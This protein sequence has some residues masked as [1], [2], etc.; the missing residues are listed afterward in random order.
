MKLK[1]ILVKNVTMLKNKQVK[2]DSISYEADGIINTKPEEN[3]YFKNPHINEM[4]KS[5]RIGAESKSSYDEAKFARFLKK[6]GHEV[7]LPQKRGLRNN[8]CQ[9][10]LPEYQNYVLA[11][12]RAQG[13]LVTNDDN[14][15]SDN[16]NSK[17]LKI[18]DESQKYQNSPFY[19]SAKNLLLLGSR[20]LN[21]EINNV[22]N[23][24]SMLKHYK[25]QDT[26]TSESEQTRKLSIQDRK[27]SARKSKLDTDVKEYASII[28]SYEKIN[29]TS[30][31]R[32][33]I[34][35]YRLKAGNLKFPCLPSNFFEKPEWS[36]KMPHTR[37]I[38]NINPS[39][40]GNPGNIIDKF[41]II[42]NDTKTLGKMHNIRHNLGKNPLAE[43]KSKRNCYKCDREDDFFLQKIYKQSEPTI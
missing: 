23:F 21:S 3:V 16:E 41:D 43:I 12:E 30:R 7:H 6:P 18:D 25:R 8:S 32:S 26:E 29:N 5:S 40:L 1:C 35:N 36:V 39:N 24:N 19:R 22:Q 27:F 9:L 14:E 17:Y 28:S 13:R 4:S 20:H 38:S 37:S 15:S 33:P 11:R 42:M 34:P 31:I 10:N 2:N